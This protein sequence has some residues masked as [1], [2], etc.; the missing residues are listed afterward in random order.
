MERFLVSKSMGAVDAGGYATRSSY[1]A[2]GFDSHTVYEYFLSMAKYLF[3]KIRVPRTERAF[4]LASRTP[5][6]K[7]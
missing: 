3:G 1:P 2:C 7:L 6:L 4:G 5:K